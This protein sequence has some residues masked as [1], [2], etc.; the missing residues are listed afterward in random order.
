MHIPDIVS[1]KTKTFERNLILDT[2]KKAAQLIL[3][4]GGETYR[5]EDTCR[6]ICMSCGAVKVDVL[7]IT[8]GIVL[9][10]EFDDPDSEISNFHTTVARVPFRITDLKAIEKTN[11]IS[12][13]LSAGTISIEKANKEFDSMLSSLEHP[14]KPSF[15]KKCCSALAPG[16]ASAFFSVLFGGGIH[17]F[18]VSFITA[19]LTSFLSYLWGEHLR[20]YTFIT[21]FLSSIIS[22]CVCMLFT[23]VYPALGYNFVIIGV[24]MPLVPGIAITNAVRDTMNGDLV[25]GSVRLIEALLIAIAIAA[26]FG[27]I[28]GFAMQFGII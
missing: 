17:E 11:Q 6:R 15:V 14:Q 19:W 21:T 22:A 24:I 10:V 1:K 2:S 4:N 26:G 7:S 12:R 20:L 28:M 27:F 18:F 23:A 9:S 5:A 8:T 3:Q 16:F 13:E 25:S